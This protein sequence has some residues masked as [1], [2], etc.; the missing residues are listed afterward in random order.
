[1]TRVMAKDLASKGITV[2]AVAP[3]PTGTEMF[4]KGKSEEVVRAVAGLSPFNRIGE[5]EEIARA[6]GFMCG[7]GATWVT[8]QVLRA[9]GGFA[10]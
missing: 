9:N 4:Y 5:S 3:G 7:D 2:N 10:V 1:M 6:I 8:G